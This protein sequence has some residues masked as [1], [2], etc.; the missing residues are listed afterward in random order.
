M[1][2]GNDPDCRFAQGNPNHSCYDTF[3]QPWARGTIGPRPG[4]NCVN[5]ASARRRDAAAFDETCEYCVANKGRMVPSHSG[6]VLCRTRTAIAA[7]GTKSHCSCAA[8]F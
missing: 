4:T 5:E 7:G 6:D 2:S 1:A 8:C 3:G